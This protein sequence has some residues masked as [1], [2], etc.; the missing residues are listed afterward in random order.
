MPVT[1]GTRSFVRSDFD[2]VSTTGPLNWENSPLRDGTPRELGKDANTSNPIVGVM[3]DPRRITAID[4]TAAF[5]GTSATANVAV[6]TVLIAGAQDFAGEQAKDWVVDLLAAQEQ[7]EAVPDVHV[8]RMFNGH[9]LEYQSWA[10][11]SFVVLT[12]TA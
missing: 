6:A 4:I 3:G 5:D 8:T 10:D 9:R 11:L 12:I 1:F 2:R 7:H